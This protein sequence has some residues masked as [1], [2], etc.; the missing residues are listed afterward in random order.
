VRAA[1]TTVFLSTLVSAVTLSI[2]LWVF[3][4]Q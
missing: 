3:H 1:T 4:A 2:L